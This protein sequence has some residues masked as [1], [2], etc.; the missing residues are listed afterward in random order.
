VKLWKFKP[1]ISLDGLPKAALTR[2]IFRFTLTDGDAAVELYNP[3][4]DN[5]IDECMSCT[6]TARELREWRDWSE[7]WRAEPKP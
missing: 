4:P 3:Q 1:W 7:A 2:L 5:R 6:N